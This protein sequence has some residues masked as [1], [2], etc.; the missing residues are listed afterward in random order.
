MA[1]DAAV[2]DGDVAAGLERALEADAIV[3]GHD[4]AVF[5][6]HA[7]AGINVEAV[8]V[9]LIVLKANGHSVQVNVATVDEMNAPKAGVFVGEAGEGEVLTVFEADETGTVVATVRS[10][11][12]RKILSGATTVNSAQ[13]FQAKVAGI[14]GIEEGVALALASGT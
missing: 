6:E 13:T 5:D 11:V 4:I 2:A 8:I 1:A 10:C 12:F 14:L 9:G 3:A 7:L